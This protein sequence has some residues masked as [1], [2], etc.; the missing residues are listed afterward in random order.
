MVKLMTIGSKAL[1]R[2][3][4]HPHRLPDDIGKRLA[5]MWFGSEI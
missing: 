1:E 5:S 3:R 2:G 4:L